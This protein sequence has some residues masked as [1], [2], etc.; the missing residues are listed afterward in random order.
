MECLFSAKHSDWISAIALIKKM[1]KNSSFHHDWLGSWLFHNNCP[2]SL[3]AFIQLQIS[4]TQRTV[5]YSSEGLCFSHIMWNPDIVSPGLQ[6]QLHN[7]IRDP[8]FYNLLA[9]SSLV[10]VC[11]LA[12]KWLLSSS[13]LICTFGRWKRMGKGQGSWVSSPIMDLPNILTYYI[14][15]ASFYS[16]HTSSEGSSSHKLTAHWASD[17]MAPGP[18]KVLSR[19][20]WSPNG[21]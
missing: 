19:T 7:V 18:P 6:C 9:I 2:I 17:W 20:I 5:V 1:R 14:P 3:R 12:T 10:H 21:Q 13:H 16:Y 15:L 11:L 8:A 4:D